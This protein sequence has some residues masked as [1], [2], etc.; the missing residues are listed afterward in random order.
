MGKF[1][2]DSLIT[3]ITRV[4]NLILA[5]GVSVILA[6]ALGPEGRGIQSLAILF[7]ALLLTFTNFGIPY[8]AALYAG[9]KKYTLAEILGN[10]I[11]SSFFISIFTIL[12]GLLV[13]FLFGD[14]FFQDIPRIYL[15][16]ALPI[17]PCSLFFSSISS[18]LWGLQKIKEYNFVS[19][20]Q[21]VVSLIFI[22][23]FLWG[24]GLGIKTAIIIEILPSF[25]GIIALFFLIRKIVGRFSICWN[26]SYLKDSFLYGMKMYFGGILTFLYQRLNVFIINFFLNPVAVGFYFIAYS[27]AEKI[28]LIP[29]SASFV[30]FP[31]VSAERDE[32]KLRE[33]TPL[34]CR[35]SLFI[36]TIGI[37]FLFFLAHW[38]I[39]FFYSDEFLGSVETFKIL[40]IGSITASGSGSLCNDLAARGKPML[41]NYA[42][43]FMIFLNTLMAIFLMPKLGILGAAWASAISSVA[44]FVV[45]LAMYIK[46]SGN[47]IKDVILI[48]KTDI[49]FYKNFL[50]Y[51]KDGTKSILQY[52]LW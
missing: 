17:I 32:K 34:V 36:T 6:R 23:I 33:F 41:N 18:I 42:A 38:L 15:L 1:T 31:K 52:K 40:L 24:F 3:F 27:L 16:L 48:K 25:F 5:L 14:K 21:S 9:K 30:L 47:R 4:L 49:E 35:H 39:K 29:Q 13:I 10:N 51:L 8:V 44:G 20:L 19:I 43:I 12:I 50:T 2:K 22:A 28:L 37:I 7:P 26:K 11:I 45:I 46:I